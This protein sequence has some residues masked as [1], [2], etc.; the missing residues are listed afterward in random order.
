LG[1]NWKMVTA[2]E[3]LLAT[4][5]GVDAK[6]TLGMSWTGLGGSGLDEE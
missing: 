3:E 6:V 1:N 2:T 4:G 5:A